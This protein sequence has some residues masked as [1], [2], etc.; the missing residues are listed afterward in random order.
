MQATNNRIVDLSESGAYLKVSLERLLIEREGEEALTVPLVDLAALIV[1]HPQVRYSNAVLAGIAGA[2]G[3][4]IACDAKHMPAAMLMPLAGHHL[5]TERF[6]QQARAPLPVR[7]RVWQQ[8]VR[9]KLK[10]QSRLLTRLRG[11]DRGI[12][13]LIP[14]VRSGDPANVEAQAARKYWPAL[15]ADK[16]FRRDPD[17]GDANAQLNYG[18][19]V[20]RAIVARAICG[21][22]LHPSLGIYHHN[23]YDTFCLADD[24]M[25]PFRPLVDEAVVRHV[26][27]TGQPSPLDREAKA[28]IVGSMMERFALDGEMRSLFDILARMAVSLADVFAGERE[29][30]ALPDLGSGM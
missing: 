13:A 17:G 18:Y 7:K 29:G 24:L 21:A 8:I 6:A 5:Q 27:D 30:L 4:F 25:E 23:R 10:A 16:A 26:Q 22:G 28:R 11:D 9:A 20:L 19:A 12:A 15:F 2:G 1:S 14:R 3:T